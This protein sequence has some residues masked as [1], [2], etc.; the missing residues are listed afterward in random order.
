MRQ[1][2][3]VLKEGW[4][5]ELS[6]IELVVEMARWTGGRGEAA[7]VTSRLRCIGKKKSRDRTKK[8]KESRSPFEVEVT[9][10]FMGFWM[11]LTSVHGYRWPPRGS[12]LLEGG[13]KRLVENFPY[14]MYEHGDHPWWSNP[15]SCSRFHI[16]IIFIALSTCVVSFFSPLRSTR[17]HFWS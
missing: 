14:V 13:A 8:R 15:E 2:G 3:E 6:E 5:K 16:K 10:D 17:F 11:S 4:E 12:F 7:T 9:N 1:K